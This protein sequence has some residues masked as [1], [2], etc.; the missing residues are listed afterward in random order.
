VRGLHDTAAGLPTAAL[1]DEILTPGAGQVRALIVVGGNPLASWPNRARTLRALQALELLIVVDPQYSATAEHAH[2]VFGPRFGYETPALTFGNEGITAYGLS[3]GYPEPYAQYQPSLVEPPAGSAVL[4]D[5]RIFYELARTMRLSLSWRGKPIDMEQPPRTEELLERFVQ[6]SRVPLE[7]VRRH[8][9]GAIFADPE[10]L[11]TAPPA[12]WPHRLQLAAAP[13]LE[14]LAV[15]AA[16]LDR[17]A[18][19]ATSSATAAFASADELELLLVSRREHAVYNS[20]GHRVPALARRRAYNPAYLNPAD[21]AHLGV[22]SGEM[23]RVAS[24]AGCIDAVAE[25]AADVR[26]GVIS[27]AH[28]FPAGSSANRDP[29]SAS[30]AELVDDASDCDP[31]SGLPRMSAIPVQVRRAVPPFH[32]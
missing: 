27:I 8:P 11:A 28:G 16:A 12:D 3:L 5:W 29:R 10:P 4:E 21:A 19:A 18:G 15:V 32:S 22:R 24:S 23:I 13:M 17:K 31:S 25:T 26:R 14:E 2:F 9:H 7:E 6:R 20:A 30:T 1:A